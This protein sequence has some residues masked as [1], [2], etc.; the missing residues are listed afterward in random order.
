MDNSI[1]AQLEQ[2]LTCCRDLQILAEQEAWESFTDEVEAYS[3]RLK[4]FDEQDLQG[5][6]GTSREMA[7]QL[8]ETLLL[9]DA[10]LRQSIQARLTS[11]GG[12]MAS[13]RKSRRSAQAYT[14]V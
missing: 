2:L 10:A 14:A 11:L 13:L 8:L 7:L 12:D 6:E 4:A 9:L 1:I 3:A 5:L